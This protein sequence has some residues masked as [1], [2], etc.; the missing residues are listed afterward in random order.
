MSAPTVLDAALGRLTRETCDR[1]LASFAAHVIENTRIEVR[2]HGRENVPK[3]S[4]RSYL[5]M[6]NHVSHY[7]IPVLYYVLGGR[8]R[9]VAKKELFHLPIFGRAIRDAGMIEVDRGNRMRAIASLDQAK[10]QLASGMPIWIAPEGTRSP[11]GELLPFKK[12]GFVLAF[13]MGVPI[14]PVTIVGTRNVLPAK[15]LLSTAG[16]T[17]DVTI[18]PLIESSTHA[19]LERK[20]ARDAL[21]R[22]VRNAITS[23]FVDRNSSK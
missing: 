3:D 18:H 14:L 2:V 8:M 9:M 23:A 1:R 22:E 13:E 21:M 20:A 15:G 17:V 12:G 6:S 16:A 4:S 19:K 10:A 11:S 5:V 7:D